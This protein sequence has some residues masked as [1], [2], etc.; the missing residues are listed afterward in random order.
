MPKKINATGNSSDDADRTLTR[1]IEEHRA[2]TIAASAATKQITE[3]A[4]QL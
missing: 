1:G 4:A 2:N 3:I